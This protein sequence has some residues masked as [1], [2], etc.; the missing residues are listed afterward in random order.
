MCYHLRDTVGPELQDQTQAGI[1]G[2]QQEG[3]P[4]WGGAAC[5]GAAPG[6]DLPPEQGCIISL[7][8]LS[9]WC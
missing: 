4:D 7:F 8:F 9:K 2:K 5:V 6:G 3:L 1:H